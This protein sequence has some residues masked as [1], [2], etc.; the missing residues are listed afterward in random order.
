MAQDTLAMRS[1]NEVLAGTSLT[2][3]ELDLVLEDIYK[4][5]GDFALLGC[6]A[7]SSEL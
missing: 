2:E 7:Y 5:E 6:N 1:I 4:E 3:E